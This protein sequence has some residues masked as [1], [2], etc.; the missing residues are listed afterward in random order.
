[1]NV[2]HFSPGDMLPR[3]DVEVVDV[4]PR[5][6]LQNQAVTLS[7]AD[8][9]T[10]ISRLVQA[11]IRRLEVCS[12]VNPKRVPQ[13][14]DAEELL[15][16]LPEDEATYIGLVLNL[17][18]ADRALKT[19]VHE[20]GAVC[21]ASDTFAQR[22]QGQTALESA[23]V[24]ADVVKAAVEVGRAGHV[25]IGAVFGCPFEGEVP[26]A[27]VV[28]IARR[29]AEV[30]PKEIALADTIGV[31]VPSQVAEVVTQ[32]KDVVGNIPLRAHFH[33][34]RNT[35]I[36]NVWAAYQA[37][38]RV[39]DAAVGGFGGCPFAPAATGNVATEDVL[40]TFERANITTGIDLNAVI[41]TADWLGKILDHPA[42]GAVSRAG[43]FPT[44]KEKAG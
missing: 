18:G 3:P 2:S 34:T 6:G 42:P 20:L 35:G 26:I 43:G 13:M 29:V 21:L 30:S 41:D 16:R 17:K 40:Y 33:N 39:F 24:A 9:V 36:A 37:G 19:N 28:E 1:M 14:A 15:K 4:G 44:G 10:L 25:T 27:R 8:K 38:V 11:G 23:S 12:F 7:T 32:V 31:A 5:D 22:N